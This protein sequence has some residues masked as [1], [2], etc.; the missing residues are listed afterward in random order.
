MRA[1]GP[2]LRSE[3]DPLPRAE[4]GPAEGA[5]QAVVGEEQGRP[6]EAAR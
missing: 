3:G 4:G 6:E 1:L 5:T 2:G